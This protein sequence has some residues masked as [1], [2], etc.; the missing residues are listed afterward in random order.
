[1]GPL[2]RRQIKKF[3]QQL[4]SSQ[5]ADQ[6][7][8]TGAHPSC[9]GLMAVAN[10]WLKHSQLKD[11]LHCDTTNL[12]PDLMLEETFLSLSA[13]LAC[14]ATLKNLEG[15]VETVIAEK[16]VDKDYIFVLTNSEG[17]IH[18]VNYQLQAKH[19]RFKGLVLTGAPGRAVG[20]LGRSQIFDQI[21]RLPNAETL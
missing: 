6:L 21:K 9:L 14:K 19:N 2:H 18:A 7:I 20:E 11:L 13:K 4:S 16:N 3:I 1:M 10:C 17:A 12:P 15:A 5:V 8:E